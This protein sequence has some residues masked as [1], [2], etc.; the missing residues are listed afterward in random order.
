MVCPG[1]SL[2]SRSLHHQPL[3]KESGGARGLEAGHSLSLYER[4]WLHA[5]FAGAAMV[6]PENS[7]AIFFEKR[8]S[9][10]TLTEHGR[11]ASELYRLMASR[12]RGVPHTPVAV[13]LDR[14]AGYNG[15]MDRPWG[16]APPTAADREVRDLFDHQL[17][18]GADHIHAKP[19][20]TNPEA[21]YLRSTPYGEI[22]DVLLTSAPPEVLPA[23]PVIPAGGRHRLRRGFPG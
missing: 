7:I 10:W 6:T 20:P 2:V 22:F 18:P 19:D 23:Y 4:L 3:R 16:S 17:F 12:D 8:E 14:Y 13:V 21:G 15:Y 9:P 11:K 1:K 5:W